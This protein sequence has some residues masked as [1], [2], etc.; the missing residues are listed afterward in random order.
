MFALLEFLACY[1]L[2]SLWMLLIRFT[3][4]S[5]IEI[6]KYILLGLLSGFAVTLLLLIF[7]ALPEIQK[8]NTEIPYLTPI[9]VIGPLLTLFTLALTIRLR[10]YLNK[11]DFLLR[12]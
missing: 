11:T 3:S 10:K 8:S 12:Y 4:N 2:F 9:F 5:S 1:G 6:P 7:Y